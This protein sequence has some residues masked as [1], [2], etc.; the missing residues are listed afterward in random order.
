MAMPAAVPSS[1]AVVRSVK[2]CAT[3]MT[4]SMMAAAAV[5]P[6]S[7]AGRPLSMAGSMKPRI[8]ANAKAS[9]SSARSPRRLATPSTASAHSAARRPMGSARS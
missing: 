2:P 6:T 5:R 7:R 8:T 1:A 9:P 3:Y 4:T